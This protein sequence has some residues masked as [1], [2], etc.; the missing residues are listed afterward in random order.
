MRGPLS[1]RAC[2]RTPPARSRRPKVP[3]GYS[4]PIEAFGIMNAFAVGFITYYTGGPSNSPVC[5]GAR[6]DAAGR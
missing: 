4:V 2:L 1:T 6:R 5:S 3:S